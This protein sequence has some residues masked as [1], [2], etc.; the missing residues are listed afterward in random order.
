MALT[1]EER[2]LWDNLKYSFDM[3]WKPR[4]NDEMLKAFEIS[5][6]LDRIIPP[7]GNTIQ[8][9]AHRVIKKKGY[10]S[11]TYQDDMIGESMMQMCRSLKNFNPN[12]STN[13][14]AYLVTVTNSAMA[15]VIHKENRERTIR[16]EQLELKQHEVYTNDSE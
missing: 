14:F 12:K 8:W 15:R 5:R 2:L 11:L 1:K 9:I 10:T 16:K 6:R 13:I 4:S 3:N 7:L